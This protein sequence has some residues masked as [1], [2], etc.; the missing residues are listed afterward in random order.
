MASPRTTTPADTV[1]D[2]PDHLSNILAACKQAGNPERVLIFGSTSKV[3]FAGAGLAVMGG[4]K[5]N[6]E[7]TKK[8]LFYQTIG[9]D[10]L[11]QLRHV[12]FFK[13]MAGIQAQMKRHTA[14]LKPKF[15]AVQTI[16]E[17][18]LGG[19]N[20]ADWSQPRGG[21][22]VSFNTMDGCGQAVV[23]MAAQ[24]G[25]KLTH[26]R[27][28]VFR[29]V[30]QT[31]DHPDAEAVFR[32]VRRRVPTISL[33]TV[34]RT[35]RLLTDLG[36]ISTL[37]PP[38]QRTRFDANLDRHHHFVCRQCGLIRDFYSNAFDDLSLP[39]SLKAVGSIET[40][41]VEARGLCRK[42]ANKRKSNSNRRGT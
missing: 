28:E 18:E 39:Q 3:S 29:E 17:K 11:N 42:C 27:L 12:L 15:D 16:L 32:G 23:D 14:I 40:T 38:R 8:Q 26:Q 21:Y 1:T 4:S 22:F 19:K 34:Y 6:I 30:A 2:T 7:F 13:D 41:H 20:V 9:P 36:Q 37:G 31:G 33:D 24:A 10:K 35:L 25:V 5:K